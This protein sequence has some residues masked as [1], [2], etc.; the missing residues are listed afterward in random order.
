[1]N[2]YC[3]T[4]FFKTFF[5]WQNLETWWRKQWICI[6]MQASDHA[7]VVGDCTAQLTGVERLSVPP[8]SS[9]H[10]KTEHVCFKDGSTLWWQFQQ[11]LAFAAPLCPQ[12]NLSGHWSICCCCRYRHASIVEPHVSWKVIG[13]GMLQQDCVLVKIKMNCTSGLNIIK[14][15]ETSDSLGVLHSTCQTNSDNVS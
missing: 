14:S 8:W 4:I 2:I 3:C 1:M 13:K 9:L 7:T 5:S 6:C 15:H 10:I 12:F 11:K